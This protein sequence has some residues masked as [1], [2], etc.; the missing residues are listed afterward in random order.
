[1]NTSS[2]FFRFIFAIVS[3]S[4][5]LARMTVQLLCWLA[6]VL[7]ARDTFAQTA[8][9]LIWSVDLAY[10]PSTAAPRVAPSGTIYIHSDDLYAISPDGQIVW[11][12]PSTDPKAVDVGADGT[13]YSGSGSTIFAYTPAGDLLWTFTEPPGGQGLMA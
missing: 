2:T 10:T 4:R 1:M 3:S 13:V 6:L 11:S 7:F 9:E 8:G 12:E 5:P